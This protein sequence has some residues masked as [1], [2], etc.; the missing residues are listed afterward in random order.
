M[1]S[2]SAGD[3]RALRGDEDQKK[4]GALRNLL[5]RVVSALI[6]APLAIGA[7]YFDDWPFV[8][9]WT[10][11][12]I[13]VWW[14]WTRLV[15]GEKSRS[16]LVTGVAALVLEALL[17][18]ME[19][20]ALALP[21][22][23]LGALAAAIVATRAQLWIAG[24][25]VYASVILLSPIAIRTGTDPGFE[26]MIFLFAVVWATDIAGYFAGRAIGGPKLA[27]AVSPKKTWSGA[28]GGIVGA[29]LAGGA[30]V[31]YGSRPVM[32]GVILALVLSISAQIGDL[33]E[34]MI[35]RHFQAK[36]SSGLIPGHGGV[37][38]RLDGFAAAAFVYVL[39]VIGRGELLWSV[40]DFTSW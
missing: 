17:V 2:D 24:G 8:L 1:A 11:A 12:A 28:I 30:I 37:M 10:V 5:L 14:E 22:V 19:H 7:A 15:D 39:I 26:N 9:F 21:M 31:A 25:V 6:L 3:P 18:S 16:V 34:S 23:A 33:L 20:I 38:D 13:A 40:S 35:K 29:A 27:P 4:S 36:D 32:N